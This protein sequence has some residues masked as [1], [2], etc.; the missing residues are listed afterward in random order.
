MTSRLRGRTRSALRVAHALTAGLVLAAA[1]AA[2]A[3]ANEAPSP[4]QTQQGPRQEQQPA[5]TQP[6]RTAASKAS[7][8]AELLSAEDAALVKEMALLERVDLLK[9]LD[10]FE[11]SADER[12]S[13]DARSDGAPENPKRQP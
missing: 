3:H 4:E 11:V 8:K 10:L 9:N 2:L 12:E 6:K 13:R 7:P 1:P 5:P